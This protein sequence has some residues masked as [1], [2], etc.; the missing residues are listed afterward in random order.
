MLSKDVFEYFDPGRS[1]KCKTAEA[2]KVTPGLLTK[3]RKYVPEIWAR[4][5]PEITK[6]DL[7]FSAKPYERPA[8]RRRKGAP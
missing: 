7:E 8:A 2:L 5:L 3:W 1:R 4:R 6:G